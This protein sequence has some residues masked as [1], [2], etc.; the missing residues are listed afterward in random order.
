MQASTSSRL[1]EASHAVLHAFMHA[2]H[3]ANEGEKGIA[4]ADM[5]LGHC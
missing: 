5:L 1:S 2:D 4:V 3:A